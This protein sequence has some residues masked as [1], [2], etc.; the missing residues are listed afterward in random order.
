MKALDTN[1]LVRLLTKDDEQQAQ[2]AAEEIRK[3][4]V[5]VPVTVL[6]ETEWVLR[7]AYGFDRAQIGGAL[8]GVVNLAGA[9]VDAEAAVR[10]ALRWHANGMDL[11]DA[12]HLACSGGSTE[13]VTFD[14]AM[15]SKAKVLNTKVSVR[16][17]K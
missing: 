11:A 16:L 6:L 17:L 10:Q 14:K 9:V 7:H 15:S 1:V 12:L 8:L 13:L 3:G 5:F 2:V 4:P